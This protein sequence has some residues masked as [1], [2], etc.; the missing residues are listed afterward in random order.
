MKILHI[1]SAFDVNFPG[2]ITNYVRTL[3]GSQASAGDDVFVLDGGKAREWQHHRLGFQVKGTDTTEVNS[4]VVSMHDDPKGSKALLD[5]IRSSEFD[6]VHFHLTIGVGTSFYTDFAEAGIRYVVSLHDYYL[7]CPRI[8]MM[9][10]T[11]ND[12][13]G[14]ALKKC[15]TCIG[16]LDQ[17]D[18]LHRASLKINLP[19]PRIPSKRVTIR[20]AEVRRFFENATAILAVSNRVRELYESVYPN[21]NYYVSHIG[22]ASASILRPLKT[23]SEKLRLTFIGTLA[24]FKG[25]ELLEKIALGIR[26]KDVVVQFYGRIERAELGKRIERAG[27]V[28]RGS[29]T[30]PEL[31]GIMANT[32]IG[33]V[34][35]V[36]EDNAPQVVMEFLNYGVPVVGTN[37]GG[38]PD[39]VGEDNGFLFDP[40]TDTGLESAIN[41]IDNVRL[42]EIRAL[43]TT[44][45]RLTGPDEH[46]TEVRRIY[47][48]SCAG[49]RGRS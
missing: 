20:N 30:P 4:F 29:Y 3:A 27:V 8:T 18:L 48:D 42:D 47:A 14:P 5:L 44:I 13:G 26:R 15:E 35:P 46:Q 34:L 40:R 23:D 41:F 24:K 9:D 17:V 38:I 31:S 32:D 36:W 12:C 43:G 10:Y 33:L 7:Y 11:G 25:A 21:G 49:D 45:P 37:M 6:V 39:F 16:K 22:S 1:A 28:I 19:L 2:G